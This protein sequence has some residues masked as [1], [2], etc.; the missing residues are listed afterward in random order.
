MAM[1]LVLLLSLPPTINSAQSIVIALLHCSLKEQQSEASVLVGTGF[2]EACKDNNR[3]NLALRKVAVAR[4]GFLFQNLGLLVVG[5]GR[6]VLR[7][8]EDEVRTSIHIFL[9][10]NIQYSSNSIVSIAVQCSACRTLLPF[11][12]ALITYAAYP[13]VSWWGDAALEPTVHTVFHYGW[14]SV[15]STGFCVLLLC[16]AAG[17]QHH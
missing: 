8:A 6:G 11:L 17:K 7:D 3:S 15:I 16:F 9:C 12:L 14:I 5:K 10:F 2:V 1:A 4:R 13:G